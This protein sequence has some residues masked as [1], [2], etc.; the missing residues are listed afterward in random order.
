MKKRILRKAVF[1]VIYK[2]SKENKPI[3]L[4]LKRRL[5]WKGWEFTKGGIEKNE[6]PI[7]AVKREVKEETGLTPRKII[8]HNLKGRYFYKKIIPGR[9]YIGQSFSLY[10][11]K[12]P[13]KRVILDSNEHS[14]YVWLPYNEA[15][16]KLTW[17]NQKKCLKMVH[18]SL[19]D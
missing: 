9:P 3:Y 11:A 2:I 4:L 15:I 18:D 1:V 6:S 5:H 13:H 19:V 8:N 17:G 7:N 16:K 14:E 10:S 12:V